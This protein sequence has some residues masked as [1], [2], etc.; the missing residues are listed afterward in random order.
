MVIY[1]ELSFFFYV[2]VE[3]IKHKLWEFDHVYKEKYFVMC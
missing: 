2:V 1:Q 3:P